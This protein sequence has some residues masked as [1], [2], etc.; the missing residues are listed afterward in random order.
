MD[1]TAEANVEQLRRGDRGQVARTPRVDNLIAAGYLVVNRVVVPATPPLGP[2]RIKKLPA[3]AA[4]TKTLVDVPGEAPVVAPSPS[5]ITPE[6]KAAPLAEPVAAPAKTV[7]AVKKTTKKK[8]GGGSSGNR[9]SDDKPRS[10]RASSTTGN[11]PA[12]NGLDETNVG[13]DHVAN[14]RGHREAASGQPNAG[15]A[16]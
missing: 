8:T 16:D 10:R 11:S 3:V 4:P 9:T 1:V 5:P 15:T 14:E 12:R 7:K 2:V 6:V 13:G